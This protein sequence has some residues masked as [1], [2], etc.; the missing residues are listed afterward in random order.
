M[1]DVWTVAQNKSSAYKPYRCPYD[2]AVQAVH[3]DRANRRGEAAHAAAAAEPAVRADATVR[4]QTAHGA[5]GAPAPTVLAAGAPTA[6]C[7][8]R[9]RAGSDDCAHLRRA[10]V[11][12]SGLAGQGRRLLS[13]LHNLR[14]LARARV[15]VAHVTPTK[16]INLLYVYISLT[17]TESVLL[18]SSCCT[19]ITLSYIPSVSTTDAH[20]SMAAICI[21]V[22]S[23][24]YYLRSSSKEQIHTR[25]KN[26]GRSPLIVQLSIR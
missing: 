4:V 18:I 12:K 1:F 5:R 9:D 19:V 7:G 8:A 17:T 16:G 2:P 26:A 6:Q 21:I 14:H 10:G 13:Q 15:A 23:T 3:P 22:C 11:P 25:H 24:V 20:Y